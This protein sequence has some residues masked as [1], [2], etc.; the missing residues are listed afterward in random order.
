MKLKPTINT[1][2]IPIIILILLILGF[3]VWQ[4]SIFN[5]PSGAETSYGF[6]DITVPDYRTIKLY[7][8]GNL[9]TVFMNSKDVPIYVDNI[10]ISDIYPNNQFNISCIGRANPPLIHSGGEFTLTSSDCTNTAIE[11][12]TYN[13][14]VAITYHIKGNSTTLVDAGQLRGPFR[15]KNH[16]FLELGGGCDD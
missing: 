8:D 11:G 13:I 3:V 10:T 12:N 9:N 14:R 4:L 16:S 7:T 2:K 15:V 1:S 6:K 5:C